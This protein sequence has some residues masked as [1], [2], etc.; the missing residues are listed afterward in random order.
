M[1]FVGVDQITYKNG[2]ESTLTLANQILSYSRSAE[3]I[4][5]F[6]RTQFQMESNQ[7]ELKLHFQT[8]S[9]SLDIS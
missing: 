1:K 7:Y 9:F 6:F 3:A 8:S 5:L 4:P 2:K